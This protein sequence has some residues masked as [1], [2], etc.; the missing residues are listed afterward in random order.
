M[1]RLSKDGQDLAQTGG[2]EEENGPEGGQNV[3]KGSQQGGALHY[4]N[5]ST[6]DLATV[7]FFEKTIEKERRR[8]VTT[9]QQVMK[10][11]QKD[12]LTKQMKRIIWSFQSKTKKCE[13]DM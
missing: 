10:T 6:F 11:C 3:P 5:R 8:N 4:S 7:V 1:E 2:T 13:S 9:S 12:V